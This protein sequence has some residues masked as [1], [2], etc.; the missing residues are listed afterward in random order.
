MKK[1]TLLPILILVIGLLAIFPIGMASQSNMTAQG[2][3][4]QVEQSIQPNGFGEYLTEYYTGSVLYLD[5]IP[6]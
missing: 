6:I 5:I 1:K 4:M 2:A 3:T